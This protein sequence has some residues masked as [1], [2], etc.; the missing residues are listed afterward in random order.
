MNRKKCIVCESKDISKIIDL[1][2]HPFADTFVDEKKQ[3]QALPV[4]NLSCALCNSC[5]HVQTETETDPNER[6]NLFDYSYTSSNSKTSRQ[7]WNMFCDDIVQ[8]LELDSS[9]KICEI[10][11]NDGYLLKC[12]KEKINTFVYGIDA[13]KAMCEIAKENNVTSENIVFELNKT[14]ELKDKYGHSNLVIANNV[15]NHS[16][17]PVSFTMGVKELLTDKGFFVFEVPYWKS[18]VETKKID[19]IYHEHVSYFTAT[20]LKY[21]LNKCGFVIKKIKLVEYHG[22]SLR[23]IAQKTTKKENCYDLKA[24]LDQE[25]FLFDENTYKELNNSLVAAKVK[26]LIELLEYKKAGHNVVA[27]GAAAKGNT[28]LN[29]LNLNSSIVDCVTDISQ[30]KQGKKTPLSNINICGD[31]ILSSYDEVCAIILSWN[32][33]KPIKDKMKKIN[34]KIKYLNFYEQ[35]KK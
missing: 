18:T 25:K 5:K 13:S 15:Y 14:P 31:D 2:M 20:S 23:V 29:Y 27:I 17:D 9:T 28:L 21:L 4:Y 6:Y 16:D 30:Y 1:G 3:T 12:F 35:V 22:G 7:H 34:S 10:G 32:L 24:F 8:A 11:S 33:D 19:Q 26:F